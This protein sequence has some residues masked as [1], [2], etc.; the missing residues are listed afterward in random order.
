MV[1][2]AGVLGRE[3]GG[4]S[5]THAPGPMR[6]VVLGDETSAPQRGARPDRKPNAPTGLVQ[7][8]HRVAVAA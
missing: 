7:Q 4:L 3:P 1:C 8:N 5:P 2:C 6:G